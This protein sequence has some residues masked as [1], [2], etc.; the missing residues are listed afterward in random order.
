MY[1]N[2][3]VATDG[4]KPSEKAMVHAIGLAGKLGAKITAFYAAPDYPEPVYSEGII[5]EMMSRKDY[6]AMAAADAEKILAKIAKKAEAA[7]VM[8]ETRHAL[9]RAPWE[10]ILAAA[11]KYKCDAI[12]MGSHGR[13]GLAALFLGSETQKVLAHSKLPVI[14]AR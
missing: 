2:L 11:R 1:T 10:A 12:V 14:V 7:G 3:L 13:G 4:S 9:S 5:Y 6:A 8:C